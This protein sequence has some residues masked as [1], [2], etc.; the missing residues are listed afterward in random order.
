M[1]VHHAHTTVVV[2]A[3]ARCHISKAKNSLMHCSAFFCSADI[4]A[5]DSQPPF[6][7]L[8]TMSGNPC[9]GA[10]K[11]TICY[12]TWRLIRSSIS[13]TVFAYSVIRTVDRMQRVSGTRD[14][15]DSVI[16][17]E[18]KSRS[19]LQA[20][21]SLTM[22]LNGTGVVPAVLVNEF[23]YGY[24]SQMFHFD[25]WTPVDALEQS[26][27]SSPCQ[28]IFEEASKDFNALIHATNSGAQRSWGSHLR[29][30]TKCSHDNNAKKN[31]SMEGI[32]ES[33]ISTSRGFNGC[34]RCLEHLPKR[35]NTAWLSIRT[36]TLRMM[37]CRKLHVILNS[38]LLFLMSRRAYA[39]AIC[40]DKV[41]NRHEK[42][43]ID[44][45][46][47]FCEKHPAIAASATG[48]GIF[49]D[50]SSEDID[51]CIDKPALLAVT[52]IVHE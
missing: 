14:C 25:R 49:A 17:V 19:C 28:L 43:T 33:R 4:C 23:L 2:H 51:A 9:C 21:R 47:K 30:C 13:A 42:R 12:R 29:S 18:H 44:V 37:N 15:F 3:K 1:D 34:P 41:H 5:R 8:L 40:D 20:M 6:P 46:C 22:T 7:V 32:T 50:I 16:N 52:R 10:N 35:V 26:C 31:D 24:C 11:C 48:I 38:L 27:A 45:E 36:T 39:C